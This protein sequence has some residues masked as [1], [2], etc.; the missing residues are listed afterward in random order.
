MCSVAESR[1]AAFIEAI[2]VASVVSKVHLRCLNGEMEGCD[3]Y[4]PEY[5]LGTPSQLSEPDSDVTQYH[6][7]NTETDNVQQ[8]VDKPTSSIEPRTQIGSPEDAVHGEPEVFPMSRIPPGFGSD[9]SVD[10]CRDGGR[11]AEKF[12]K[13]I[14]EKPLRRMSTL[15]LMSKAITLH[16]FNA[17]IIVRLI[18]FRIH[19][20]KVLNNKTSISHKNSPLK[21]RQLMKQSF[22]TALNT[23]NAEKREIFVVNKFP[24]IQFVLTAAFF[25]TETPTQVTFEQ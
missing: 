5:P 13:L 21:T 12:A 20:N 18:C 1:E 4:A 3:C 8:T 14:F 6:P 23:S 24:P 17:A 11:V 19:Y 15:D 2:Q 7:R 25:L 16:N 9:V 10:D 22:I